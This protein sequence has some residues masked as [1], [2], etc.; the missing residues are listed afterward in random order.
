MR[1]D[2]E[3]ELSVVAPLHNE[4]ETAQRLF[5]AIR[6]AMEPLGRPFEVLLVNDGSS[7][8]TGEI[9]DRLAE[10]DP[11]LRP[12]HLDGNFGE[13]AALC[14]GFDQSRGRIV[15]TLDGDLQND[16]ADLPRLLELLETRGY[17]AVSGWRRKRQEA[18]A[19]RVL[20]SVAANW[21]ISR[22]TGVPSR[23][24][25]C[26]LKAYRAEVV[27]G[28]YLPH[29]LHRFMPAVFGV[30]APEFGQ[31]EVMD[32][33]RQSGRSHYGLSRFFAVL[34]DLTIVRYL[35]AHAD[36]GM[37]HA[38]FLGAAA[39]LLAAAALHSSIWLD[40]AALLCGLYAGCMAANLRRWDQAQREKTFRLRRSASRVG[41]CA[42]ASARERTRA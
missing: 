25:G 10:E 23:D 36:R 2:A 11:R 33:R 5:E 38:T 37:A 24:N 21:L 20:P 4:E 42:A 1:A 34:R 22:V 16:P 32:R 26:G 28:V 31:V 18:F 29:G 12:V 3:P 39:V 13:A 35:P 9:L 14:A 40:V 7:D 19:S 6:A 41:R 15:L 27:R 30:R 17:R 8:S